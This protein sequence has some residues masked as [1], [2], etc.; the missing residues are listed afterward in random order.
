MAK[1]KKNKDKAF[2]K[3]AKE[4]GR[5]IEHTAVEA[6]RKIWLAGIGAYG[7]AYDVASKGANTATVQSAEMFDDL[8]KRGGELETDVMALISNNP[9]VNTASKSAQKVAETSQKVQKKVRE[10]FDARMERMRDLLGLGREGSTAD[11][12]ASKLEKLEDDV[13]A[14]TKG[15]LKKG[16]LM[17]KKR[18]SR[19][20]DEIDAYVGDVEADEKPAKAKKKKSAKKAAKKK[21][22]SKTTEAPAAKA[23]A[24]VKA[25]AAPKAAP[26]PAK[27]VADDLT[28][29]NG[30]GP[31]MAKRLADEGV[32]SFGQLAVLDKDAAEALDAKIG[33]NGRLIR[34]AWVSQA[35]ALASA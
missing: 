13:A 17:L 5:A 12:L 16:D 1:K 27:I 30:V 34:D 3:K 32:V 19:L 23:K 2:R 6:S 24:P 10:R 35:K 26:K 28:K 18:L 33:G 14:A 31:A 8:V 7:M 25:K 4:T 9:A 21:T 15:A 22:V 29:I 11:K 20:S